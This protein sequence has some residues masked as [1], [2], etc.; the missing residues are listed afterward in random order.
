MD[1]CIAKQIQI[2]SLCFK[3]K[4]T[5]LKIVIVKLTAKQCHA[6][7]DAK[8]FAFVLLEQEKNPKFSFRSRFSDLVAEITLVFSND[9]V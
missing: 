6:P 9:E 3:Y 2:V 4:Y 1:I 5:L 8:I 7:G